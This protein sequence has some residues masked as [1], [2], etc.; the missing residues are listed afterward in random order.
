MEQKM[1]L[2]LSVVLSDKSDIESWK[3]IVTYYD[4]AKTSSIIKELI[5]DEAARIDQ[6]N[7]STP[8]QVA[9]TN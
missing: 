8:V 7:L 6:E 3:K 2:P 9:P 5:R 1:V 4:N